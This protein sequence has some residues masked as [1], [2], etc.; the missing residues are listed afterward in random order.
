MI[1][2]TNVLIVWWV[3]ACFDLLSVAKGG[4]LNYGEIYDELIVFTWDHYWDN[5]EGSWSKN[6]NCFNDF[7]YPSVW[8]QAVIGKAIAESGDTEKL[9]KVMENLDDY[10]NS[11]GWYSST[12][13]K[14]ND[15]YVDDNAQVLWVLLDSYR[16]RGSSEDLDKAVTLMNLIKSQVVDNGGVRW[17]INDEY[18]ASISTSE[19]ALAA[20]KLYQVNGDETL[21]QFAKASIDWLFNNLQDP[22]DKL[23]YDGKSASSGDVNKGKLTYSVGTMISTLAYLSSFTKDISWYVKA[24]SL[25]NASLDKDGAFYTEEGHWNNPIRYSHLLFVG[26]EDLVTVSNTGSFL[27]SKMYQGYISE[28][29][30]QA[31]YIYHNLEISPNLYADDVKQ[32]K[33]ASDSKTCDGIPDSDLIENASAAQIFYAMSKI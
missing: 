7:K 29:K 18:L 23:I 24:L 12:T 33:A 26:I 32:A 3:L 14:D 16:I 10:R 25:V 9:G 1:I 4:D 17:K 31:E 5:D 6:P 21:L 28:L 15:V 2:L 27:Q 22:N 30:T 13:A 11:D 19:L 8:D 20:I